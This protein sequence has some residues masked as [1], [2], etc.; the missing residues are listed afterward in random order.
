MRKLGSGPAFS[1]E[2][3]LLISQKLSGQTQVWVID[4]FKSGD[5]KSVRAEPVEA[6][7]YLGARPFDRLRANKYVSV[8]THEDAVN[9]VS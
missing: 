8:L 9:F 2:L 5:K 6:S 4:V 3:Y 1:H 7:A